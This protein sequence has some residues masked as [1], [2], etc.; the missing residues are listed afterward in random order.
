MTLPERFRV[1]IITLSDRAHSG[2]YSDLSG[3]VVVKYVKYAMAAA[4]WQCEIKTTI[5][6]DDADAL[7]EA[8][9][10]TPVMDLIITTGGTGI[11]PRDFT[12]DVVKPLLTKEI[13]GVMELIRVKYGTI[14]PNALLSRGVAG[15][16]GNTLIYTLPGS[17]KAVHEYMAEIVKTLEH[18]FYML[19]G[20][21]VHK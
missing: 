3:P 6:P 12:V 1:H 21:D 10:A 16:I 8:L 5:I 13:P 18:T 20:I 11:G 4:G 14:N 2:A 7:R 19:Y 17:V 9:T 15:A